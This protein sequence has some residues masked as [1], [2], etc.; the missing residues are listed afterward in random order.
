MY[1]VGGFLIVCMREIEQV[2]PKMTLLWAVPL[3]SNGTYSPLNGE[4]YKN[5]I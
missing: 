4:N 3:T 1:V 2:T 5:S